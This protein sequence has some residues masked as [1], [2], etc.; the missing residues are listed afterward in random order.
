M[1]NDM[2]GIQQN[3]D[4]GAKKASERVMRGLGYAEPAP[5]PVQAL[6]G[7]VERLAVALNG[8]GVVAAMVEERL[9]CISLPRETSRSERAGLTSA[10]ALR[11]PLVCEID[12]QRERIE[13]ITAS[14]QDA[15]NRLE[16]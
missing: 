10:P 5:A 11:S 2:N 16:V 15:L 14:L 3:Y 7:A 6:P 12:K 9:G 1:E 13:N 4:D 8:L